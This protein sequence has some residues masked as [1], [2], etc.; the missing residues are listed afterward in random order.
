MS[1]VALSELLGATVRDA[2]GTVRGRVREI[3]VAPQDHPTRIAYLI[4]KTADGERDAAGRRDRDRPAPPC[5][6]S[7]MLPAG[8]ASRRPTASCCSSAT[9]STSKSST[10]TAARS[11]ASTTSSSTRRRSTA[12]CSST[13]SPST[14]A[15]AAPSGASSKGIVP[16]F[17]LRALL[18]KIPPRVIPWQYV[19]LLETD[20]ARRVKLKIAYEGPLQAASGRHRRHRR[21]SAAGRARSGVRDDRRGSGRRSA[22]GDRSGHPGVDRRVARQG[23]RRR[24][25]RGDGPRRRG[26]PARRADRR[27]G[28][29]RFSRRWSPRS[30]RKSRSCSS[31]ASTPRPAA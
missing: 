29:A 31:S 10:S 22:R 19:D 11:S 5:A 28:R 13:S 21:G 26:R 17:T 7:T 24:H 9:S 20:P 23:P 3:A 8:S 4:V 6:P 1:L 16:A 30:G 18:E 12:T 2:T 27:R 15:R 25:R 14:S